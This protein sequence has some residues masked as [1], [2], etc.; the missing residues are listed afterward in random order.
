[1]SR[2][3]ASLSRHLGD[4]T[5]IPFRGSLNPKSRPSPFLSIDLVLVVITTL[6]AFASTVTSVTHDSYL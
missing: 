3:P 1:M 5:G 6:K 4:G 2:M